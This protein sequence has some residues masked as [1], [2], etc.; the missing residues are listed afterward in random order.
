[1]TE[2]IGVCGIIAAL[3]ALACL[4]G[5]GWM[6]GRLREQIHEAEKENALRGILESEKNEI[7]EA[8]SKAHSIND[9]YMRLLE[10]KRISERTVSNY[11]KI[12]G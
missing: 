2:I 12:D 5:G 3:A 7:N 11:R 9:P 6:T 1:M 8:L 10:L 4:F